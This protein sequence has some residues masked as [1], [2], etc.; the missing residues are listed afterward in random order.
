MPV[1]PFVRMFAF[2]NRQTDFEEIQW[3]DAL[4]L[5]YE[6]RVLVWGTFL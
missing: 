3:D 6:S 1:R 4:G 5:E 2:F